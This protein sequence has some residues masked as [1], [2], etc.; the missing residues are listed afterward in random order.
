LAIL[1]V[2]S[3]LRR[4]TFELESVRAVGD[5]EVIGE[6][7]ADSVLMFSF[8]HSSFVCS[9]LPADEKFTQGNAGIRS[10]GDQLISN[11]VWYALVG[12]F[13]YASS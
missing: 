9:P 3:E 10:S 7:A 1:V 13:K 6:L 8:L 5:G 11:A 2:G 12:L 4:V